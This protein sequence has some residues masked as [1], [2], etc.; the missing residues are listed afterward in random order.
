M[1]IPTAQEFV[2][3]YCQLVGRQALS[4]KDWTF[5]VAFVAFR[6]ACIIQGVYD[7]ALKGEHNDRADVQRESSVA[8]II[9]HCR[10]R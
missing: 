6:F 4:T 8:P 2:T 5:Y 1:G 10:A 7:R 9:T 3:Q